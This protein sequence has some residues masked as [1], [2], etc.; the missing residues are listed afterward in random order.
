MVRPNTAKTSTLWRDHLL[1]ELREDW[2][3][4]KAGSLLAAP[5]SAVVA[6]GIEASPELL[7]KAC[8]AMKEVFVPTETRFLEEYTLTHSSIVVTILDNVRELFLSFFLLFKLLFLLLQV[9][10]QLEQYTLG[11]NGSFTKSH[12]QTPSPGMLAVSSWR[13]FWLEAA[14]DVHADTITFRYSDFITP[15]TLYL[16]KLDAT[17]RKLVTLK[18]LPPMFDASGMKLV[19]YHATSK[20]GTKIPYFVA[21]PKNFVAD[22]STATFLYGYGGFEVTLTPYYSGVIGNS[23]LARGGVYVVANIRG[24]GEFGPR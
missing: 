17:D 10:S 4:W 24:G 19:Q 13:D 1:L 7:E 2:G 15:T 8:A 16:L 23:I 21:F 18:S 20:D 12:V 11:A 3:P 22:G 5:L 9:V 14:N 6:P